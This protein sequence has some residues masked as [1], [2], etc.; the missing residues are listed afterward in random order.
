MMNPVFNQADYT[1][2]EEQTVYQGFFSLN[3]LQLKH[4]LFAGGWSK[5]FSRELFIRGLAVG[6]LA[7]DP[8]LDKVVM[9]EQFRV[10]ALNDPISPWL[11]EV[12]AGIIEPGE[13]P[14]T[15]AYRETQEEAGLDILHLEHLYTYYSS[16]GGSDEQIKL[17]LGIVDSS[18]VKTGDLGGLETE[19]EDL[20]I[21]VLSREAALHESSKGRAANSMSI[22]AL[23]WLA[24]NY[25]QLEANWLK[26]PQND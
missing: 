21:T 24:I 11:L 1:L 23:Q 20:R 5:S 9:V 17:Y 6:L 16:P 25:Q 26:K 7:Y 18:Q 2:L 4:R 13:Q 15:V 8:W 12:I 19:N 22:I 14:E 10:G 3:K